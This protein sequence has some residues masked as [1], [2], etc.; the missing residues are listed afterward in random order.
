SIPYNLQN[1][2]RLHVS[3]RFKKQSYIQWERRFQT[4]L[5]D[6]K[7]AITELIA[8]KKG[9]ATATCYNCLAT[10]MPITNQSGEG[11]RKETI[12]AFNWYI[13]ERLKNTKEQF[14]GETITD[15]VPAP[16]PPTDATPLAAPVPINPVNKKGYIITIADNSGECIVVVKNKQQEIV[17]AMTLVEWEKNKEDNENQYGKVPPR[18]PAPLPVIGVPAVPAVPDLVVEAPV[19]TPQALLAE[20]H[21][22]ANVKA[23]TTHT[24]TNKE[25]GA[26]QNTTTVTLKNGKKEVYNLNNVN[27]RV[28]YIKKYGDL[29]KMIIPV[30]PPVPAV[31]KI[32]TV[33]P[34]LHTGNDT[35]PHPLVIIDGVIKPDRADGNS[36]NA[37]EMKSLNVLERKAAIDK[38][39]DKGK[40]GAVEITTH[41]P[42]V[43]TDS[44]RPRNF[45]PVKLMDATVSKKFPMTEALVV[46]D[47]RE[48]PLGTNPDDVVKAKDIA[49]MTV[50][51]G[52]MATDKYGEKGKKGVIELRTKNPIPVI[53]GITDK[54]VYIKDSSTGKARFEI[55]KGLYKNGVARTK[56]LPDNIIYAI[57]GI[58]T[59]KS[60]AEKIDPLRVKSVSILQGA[61]AMEKY[62]EDGKNDVIEIILKSNFATAFNP[63]HTIFYRPLWSPE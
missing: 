44:T 56:N 34:A 1:D 42:G 11:L 43:T 27:D 7:N 13:L 15:T 28:N 48:L 46:I 59:S 52:K 17:K 26:Y 39:G 30:P 19:M 23:I 38:Y 22:P 37:D 54:V 12:T 25:T 50:L 31:K 3:L 55:W 47:G 60:N 18:P 61:A 40:Y 57:N 51:K 45:S 29:P 49:S 35:T 41:N 36:V 32:A 8:L 6:G 9:V 16:V 10:M 4:N 21:L 14:I 63:E 5:S 58:K 2:N 62:K 24:N 33:A 20:T 53:P